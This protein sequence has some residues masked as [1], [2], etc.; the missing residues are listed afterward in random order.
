MEETLN[1]TE[2]I[3]RL[4]RIMRRKPSSPGHHSHGVGK[5]LQIIASNDSATSSELAE[6]MD[7]RPSSLTE[8]LN[9]LEDRGIIT[10]T[11]DTNDLRVVRVSI[12]EQGQAEMKQH[13]KE[14]RQLIDG[15]ADCLN[16][17]EKKIFCELC[18]RLATYAEKQNGEQPGGQG[19]YDRPH[20][21]HGRQR[22]WE[23]D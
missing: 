13:E 12:S 15:L 1:V 18:D 23:E 9:R 16:P 17:E 11:R 21:G 22:F 7:I 6:M 2:S 5:L 14:K 19:R 4:V 8:L 10:R 3:F 20:H